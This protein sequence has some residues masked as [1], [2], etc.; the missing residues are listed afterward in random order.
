MEGGREG[1]RKKKN[2]CPEEEEIIGQQ[3]TS[4]RECSTTEEGVDMLA[5]P[6]ESQ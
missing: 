6:E 4:G 3:I 5:A 1:E 2:F